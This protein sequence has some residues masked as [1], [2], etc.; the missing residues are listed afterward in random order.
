MKASKYNIIT[1]LNQ[2][3]FLI[4][5]SMSNAMI[6]V[7]SKYII[8]DS[9][10]LNLDIITPEEEKI[11]LKNG[12]LVKKS[13]DEA[14]VLKFHNELQKYHSSTLEVVIVPTTACNAKCDYCFQSLNNVYMSKEIADKAISY[15][16]NRIKNDK[17]L[18]E[19]QL[20]WF[21][22]EPLLNNSLEIMLHIQNSLLEIAKNNDINYIGLLTTNG[23]LISQ[24]IIDKL[25]ING[26]QITLDGAKD[27][28]NQVKKID[29]FDKV[30]N[31]IKLLIEKKAH[32][33]IRVN[34]NSKNINEFYKVVDTLKE[35]GY[36]DKIFVYSAR[37]EDFNEN[38]KEND[39]LDIEAYSEIEREYLTYLSQSGFQTAL[40]KAIAVHCG[41][42][43]YNQIVI[44]PDGS[45]H[46]CWMEHD[47]VF[48]SLVDPNKKN[49]EHYYN[50]LTYDSF[51]DEECLECKIFPI[52]LGGC[53]HVRVTGEKKCISMKYNI[54]KWAL[55]WY[56]N[57][58][59][60]EYGKSIV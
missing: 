41:A 49:M 6:E 15:I 35:K 50:Y 55:T 33:S 27:Y 58:K 46:K 32:I 43:K 44:N 8:K 14:K 60:K 31:N 16:E 52:C 40:P 38:V 59:S 25:M 1:E 47:F 4:F 39:F 9:G 56:K 5:N 29:I 19:L 28:H 54:D 13:I 2:N 22:G 18:K 37:I 3:S 53:P 7:E 23:S 48:D 21:G 34:I 42:Q 17:N 36:S 26:V 10:M 51:S 30:V 45:I 24:E 12:I 11:L 20:V 57:K